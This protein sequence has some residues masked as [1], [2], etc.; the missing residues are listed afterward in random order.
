MVATFWHM[1]FFGR[2]KVSE[3]QATFATVGG[4]HLQPV[5]DAPVIGASSL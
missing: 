2:P 3:R 4:L 5:A 1:T